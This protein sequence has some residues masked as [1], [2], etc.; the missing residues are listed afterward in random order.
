MLNNDEGVKN[1]IKK[2]EQ[3][4]CGDDYPEEL[5]DPQGKESLKH[6]ASG[7]VREVYTMGESKLLLVATDRISA[8]DVILTNVS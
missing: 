1:A 6:I 8:Y 2:D 3:P 7:K 4:S 5:A